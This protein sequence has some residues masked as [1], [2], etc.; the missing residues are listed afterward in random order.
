M[1]DHVFGL[2]LRHIPV[3][4]IP[5]ALNMLQT[6]Q[7]SDAIECLEDTL[8]SP[9]EGLSEKYRKPLSQEA[10]NQLKALPA[11]DRA[12]MLQEWRHFF[13]SYLTDSKEPYADSSPLS[14][15]WAYDDEPHPWLDVLER[16]DLKMSSFGPAFEELYST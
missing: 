15:F 2:K 5:D 11:S 8:K 4:E 16:I 12:S 10:K 7:V 1:P 3:D 6:S 9:L 13:R 14:Q